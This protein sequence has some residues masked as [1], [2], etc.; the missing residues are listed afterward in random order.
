MPRATIRQTGP[1]EVTLWACDP[2]TRGPLWRVFQIPAGGGLVFDQRG[3]KVCGLL[4][5]EGEP[6]LAD[7]G[8]DLL[9]TVRREWDAYRRWAIS[10]LVLA[11]KDARPPARPRDRP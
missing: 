6:L 1:S 7:D 8:I 5:K 4:L 10:I 3:E 9:G 2:L 11:E